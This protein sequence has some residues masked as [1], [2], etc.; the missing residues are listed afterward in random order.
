VDLQPINCLRD[1]YQPCR[2]IHAVHPC[3]TCGLY[4]KRLDYIV[5]FEPQLFLI[6]QASCS[7]SLR[8]SS[9]S[10]V[11]R[12]TVSTPSF[13]VHALISSAHSHVF[14]TPPPAPLVLLSQG[15]D[16]RPLFGLMISDRFSL[17][18]DSKILLAVWILKASEPSKVLDRYLLSTRNT[19]P[20][21]HAQS[22]S[23]LHDFACDL[24]CR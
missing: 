23:S 20:S 13:V 2:H 3:G 12:P 18:R 16:G 19:F 6:V 17:F 10:T 21:A 1:R 5:K 11:S 4:R 14:P 15:P 7:R 24:L 22:T 9:S 8:Q